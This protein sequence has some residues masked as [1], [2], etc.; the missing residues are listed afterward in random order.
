MYLYKDMMET[1]SP[2]G[3]I[4]RT[5]KAMVIIPSDDS[6]YIPVL[7]HIN[8]KKIS[9]EFYNFINN[10]MQNDVQPIWLITDG[11]KV[12]DAIVVAAKLREEGIVD[13]FNGI[14]S[15]YNVQLNQVT[16]VNAASKWDNL[17]INLEEELA[18]NGL[19][20][21]SQIGSAYAEAL[22]A[23]FDDKPV[24]STHI[25]GEGEADYNT[26]ITYTNLLSVKYENYSY[27]QRK[28]LDIFKPVL[29]GNRCSCCGR[30]GNFITYTNIGAKLCPKC[31]KKIKALGGVNLINWYYVG[32]ILQ[33][34]RMA[35]H[36]ANIINCWN[37]QPRCLWC[38]EVLTSHGNHSYKCPKCGKTTFFKGG[39]YYDIREVD[40][41]QQV[42]KIDRN[43][44]SVL[45]VTPL[46]L[47][48][49]VA[50]CD[51]CGA[52]AV[53]YK[54]RWDSSTNSGEYMCLTCLRKKGDFSYEA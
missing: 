37:A 2:V 14:I 51:S 45:S 49:D 22:G 34:E 6:E 47:S 18:A 40:G 39:V 9:T 53:D 29:E 42:Y 54:Y 13:A 15:I 3:E 25:T 30:E 35:T 41:H 48:E 12:S 38:R 36:I 52:L 10:V 33:H 1:L 7:V 50:K 31:A 28:K 21:Y 8:C 23:I 19:G 27:K 4:V 20:K 11:V 5:S 16:G 43:M 32:F 46:E 44:R 26:F 24:I 17:P